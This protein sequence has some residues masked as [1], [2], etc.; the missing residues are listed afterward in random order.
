MYVRRCH[1]GGSWSAAPVIAGCDTEADVQLY[2]HLPSER[3][4]NREKVCSEDA[5]SERVPHLS[6]DRERCTHGGDS[7]NFRH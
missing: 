2:L 1:K 5:Q 3:L 6:P 7:S 4:S